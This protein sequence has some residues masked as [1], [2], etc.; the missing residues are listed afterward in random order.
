LEEIIGAAKAANAH[1]FICNFPDG[2][3]SYV[4]ERGQR[5]SGGERQRI[6][7]ARAIL[8]NPKILV[9]D[10]ATASVDTETER[11]I[12][13][14]LERLITAERF[15]LSLTGSQRSAMPIGWWSSTMGRSLKSERTKNCWLWKTES[16]RSLWPCSKRSTSSARTT[17]QPNNRNL[18]WLRY[19]ARLC[20]FASG[21]FEISSAYGL[22]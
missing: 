19:Y 2:Y 13:E 20:K 14:A 1:D 8:H 7:I 11:M 16:T 10:E 12:Q 21:R 6:A 22:H 5:L 9:L 17:S 18:V 4:G 3:D 15:L